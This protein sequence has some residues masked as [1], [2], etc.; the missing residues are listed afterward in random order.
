MCSWLHPTSPTATTTTSEWNILHSPAPLHC[1][2]GHVWYLADAGI[3]LFKNFF[4]Y[5]FFFF[6][7]Q[8]WRGKAKNRIGRGGK[9]G[10]FLK[11]LVHLSPQSWSDVV[12]Q[13]WRLLPA[14]PAQSCRIHTVG[15]F[16][17]VKPASENKYSCVIEL[18]S[19]S[20]MFKFREIISLVFCQ[21]YQLKV[22]YNLGAKPS[23]LYS[24][25]PFLFHLIMGLLWGLTLFLQ[26]KDSGFYFTAAL[27][28]TLWITVWDS[29]LQHW[30]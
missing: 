3:L 6:C 26:F 12:G 29:L 19:R 8:F 18:A 28:M 25:W 27:F 9:G 30:L 13:R 11:H 15:A 17:H 1:F 22:K 4:F 5:W 14:V 23:W 2:Q 7:S 24:V 20:Y 16:K 21:F 10:L